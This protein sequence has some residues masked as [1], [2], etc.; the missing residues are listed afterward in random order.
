M[1]LITDVILK[2]WTPKNEFRGLSKKSR[3][4]GPLEKQ[5]GKQTKNL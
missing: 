2:L 4:R 1:T 3:L 5:H